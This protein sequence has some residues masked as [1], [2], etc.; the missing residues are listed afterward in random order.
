[1]FHDIRYYMPIFSR[2]QLIFCQID[3]ESVK[4]TDLGMAD[5]VSNLQVLGG[6]V[7]VPSGSDAGPSPA[8]LLI[9]G[10]AAVSHPTGIGCR[11]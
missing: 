5:N 7:T 2:T 8:Q 11:K 10:I 9:W 4:S 6:G 3:I 1:M